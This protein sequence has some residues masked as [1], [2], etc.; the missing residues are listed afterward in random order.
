MDS[1]IDNKDMFP[2]WRKIWIGRL[3][4]ECGGSKSGNVVKFSEVGNGIGKCSSTLGPCE[5]RV[6]N[7][8]AMSGKS[9]INIGRA[10]KCR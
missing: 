2:D 3:G 8:A 9:G 7:W 4:R 6:C 10:R 5:F 1:V